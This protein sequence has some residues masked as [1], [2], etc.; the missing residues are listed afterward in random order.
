[1]SSPL[2][3]KQFHNEDLVPAAWRAQT[4]ADP[5]WCFN[6]AMLRLRSGWL[7][8]YRVVLSD[9]QRRIAACLLDEHFEVIP[10]S[11]IPLSDHIRFPATAG[12][13]SRATSWFADPRLYRINERLQLYFNSGWHEPINHQ[14]LVEL[15][16]QTFLPLAPARELALDGPRQPLEK[17]WMLLDDAPD[18]A[19]YSPDPHVLMTLV[20]EDDARLL[21]RLQQGPG[22]AISAALGPG[23]LRGGTPP[24]RRGDRYYSFCHF[25]A[26]S[27]EA[28]N[29]RACVY[30]FS[31]NPPHAPLRLPGALLDLP[32]T[33]ATL[34]RLNP[35]VTDVVY[36][37]A[38]A[39]CNDAWHIAYGVNDE[40]CA[41]AS[42]SAASIDRCTAEYTF[43][44]AVLTSAACP[45]PA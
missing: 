4:G 38:A 13:S 44:M 1:M 8:A 31:A 30:V 35:A 25:I 39:W 27:A 26:S 40:R 24:V 10:G 21:Y 43:A 34:P 29:Y 14:F 9:Q 33:S 37:C 15:D 6:P 28:V 19:V 3:S 7:F 22:I 32:L 2:Y 12:Y 45:V 5:V 17:N 41:I 16:L 18:R 42:F 11:P 23:H 20:D 36:P